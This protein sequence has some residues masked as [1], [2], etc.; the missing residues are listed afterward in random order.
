M[1]R[2]INQTIP[3]S[4]QSIT[5]KDIA[6]VNKVLKSDFITQGPINRKFE[7]YISKFVKSKFCLTVNTATNALTIACKALDLLKGDILWTSANSFVASSNCGLLCGAKVDFIDINLNDYNLSIEKLEQKLLLAKKNNKLPK[8]LVP[9]HFAGFPC[10]MKKIHSLARKYNKYHMPEN[11]NE[12]GVI[13]TEYANSCT[14]MSDGL[15][16]SLKRI[17]E[18]SIIRL[19][20][21]T[22]G[23]QQ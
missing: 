3:Y 13:L 5:K 22:A 1:N 15:L 23:V 21:I 14:D 7:A 9:V 17:T 12:L 11:R 6:E 4:R 2:N 19:V 16:D 8:I 10:N 18:K 20:K